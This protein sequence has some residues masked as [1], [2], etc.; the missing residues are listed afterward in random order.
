M[1]TTAEELDEQWLTMIDCTD[2]CE[3]W[4]ACESVSESDRLAFGEPP[5]S[6]WRMER[7]GGRLRLGELDCLD[8]SGLRTANWASHSHLTVVNSCSSTAWSRQPQEGQTKVARTRRLIWPL[9]SFGLLNRR[10]G[11]SSHMA[12][13]DVDLNKNS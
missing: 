4:D 3:G 6:C 12:R 1:L 2:E 8:F 13:A 9:G 7:S 10:N 5:A 11:S